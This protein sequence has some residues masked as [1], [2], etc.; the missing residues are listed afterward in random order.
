MLIRKKHGWDFATPCAEVDKIIGRGD[1]E[2][3]KP[4]RP[5]TDEAKQQARRKA[6][7]ERTLAEANDPRVVAAF[8]RKRRITVTSPALLGHAACPYFDNDDHHLVGRFPAVVVPIISPDGEII[9]AAL[10]YCAA[11]PEPRKKFLPKVHSL[12]GAAVRLFE[13][14]NR[15]LGVGEGIAN[16]LAARQLFGIPTWAALSDSGLKAWS[17]PPGVEW[18]TIFA[19]HDK[20]HAGQAA[21]YALAQRLTRDGITAEVQMPH[22]LGTDF[23]DLLPELHEKAHWR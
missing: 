4:S 20:S 17:P 11:A 21:A 18:V 19:D 16:A 5:P 22:V 23:A 15:R 10:L 3:T 13:P 7:I 8:L 9:S 14:E 2:P 1:P 6:R 12:S